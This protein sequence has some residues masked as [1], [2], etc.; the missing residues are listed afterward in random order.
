MQNGE[1]GAAPTNRE[2]TNPATEIGERIHSDLC[3]P[4]VPTGDGSRY[5]V[6]FIDEKS[7]YSWIDFLSSK[8]E[9]LSKFKRFSNEFRMLT[10]RRIQ[11]I[12]SDNGGEYSSKEFIN[13]LIDAGIHRET[14]TPHNPHQNGIAERFNRVIGEVSRTLMEHAGTPRTFWAE[15]S[16]TA[17]QF[18]IIAPPGH[19]RAG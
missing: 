15:A 13:Y 17:N 7:R 9:V 8:S 3:G 2:Q 12:R 19:F 1:G 18:E 16:R 5:F 4:F 11:S 6:S 14:T 10:K